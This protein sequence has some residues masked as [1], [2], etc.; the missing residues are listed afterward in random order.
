MKICSVIHQLQ[1]QETE[2]RISS[3]EG[4]VEETLYAN[5][6]KEGKTEN[7]YSV[8]KTMVH[9]RNKPKRPR[10][11][12]AKINTEAIM[13]ENLLSSVCEGSERLF[14]S[15]R[16]RT[17]TTHYLTITEINYNE[18]FCFQSLGTN[19]LSSM[20]LKLGRCRSLL[21]YTSLEFY[22][23]SDYDCQTFQ[24]ICTCLL[25]TQSICF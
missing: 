13:T 25:R 15:K 24:E 1:I 14:Y 16:S 22:K 2:E 3:V 6:A 19:Y 12:G 4:K 7:Y 11:E 10:T 17:S 23:L 9:K 20:H 18:Y 21:N 8:Q 5:I